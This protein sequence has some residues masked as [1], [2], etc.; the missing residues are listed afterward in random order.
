MH[1]WFE[2]LLYSCSIPLLGALLGGNQERTCA[3]PA[4][5]SILAAMLNGQCDTSDSS[6]RT[7]VDIRKCA[8]GGN[9]YGVISGTLD[10]AEIK[11]LNQYRIDSGFTC[12][13]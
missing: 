6:L 10:G 1:N 7:D 12:S 3:I 11:N 13:G 5:K 2:F 9:D 4:G 8:T